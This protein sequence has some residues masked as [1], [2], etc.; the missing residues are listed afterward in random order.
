MTPLIAI[1]DLRSSA[2][3]PRPST[4]DP[5]FS[6]EFDPAGLIAGAFECQVSAVLED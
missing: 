3:G 5:R 4:L 1:L 2:L 6:L